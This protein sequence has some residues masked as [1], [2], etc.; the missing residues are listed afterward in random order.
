MYY[1]LHLPF[2]P[3][4]NSYY[5]RGK[6]GVRIAEKGRKYRHLVLEEVQQQWGAAVAL[7]EKLLLEVVLHP[8]DKV[9]RDVDNYMKALLDSL[10][11]AGVWED[12]SQIDQLMI[13]RG[14]RVFG[15]K[16]ALYI[17]EAGPIIKL[18]SKLP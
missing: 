16:V 15:G 14:E 13:Y 6:Y 9:R 3:T 11:E 12:D 7:D 10:T 18:G 8:P 17:H 2:P 4:V 5:K 1:E